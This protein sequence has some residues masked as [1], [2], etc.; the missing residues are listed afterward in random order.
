[1]ENMNEWMAKKLWEDYQIEN[2]N[3]LDKCFDLFEFYFP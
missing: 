3:I 1:M 2:K